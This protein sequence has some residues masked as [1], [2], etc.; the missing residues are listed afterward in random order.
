MSL[1]FGDP[2]GPS[3]ALLSGIPRIVAILNG[4]VRS[5]APPE[6]LPSFSL[7]RVEVALHFASRDDNGQFKCIV[8]KGDYT[9]EGRPMPSIEASLNEAA[10][11]IEELKVF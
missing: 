3:Q 9:A 4:R 10:E 7:Y 1:S 11:L 2:A 5:S 8:V 6:A